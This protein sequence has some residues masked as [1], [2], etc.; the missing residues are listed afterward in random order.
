MT[1]KITL[2]YSYAALQAKRAELARVQY[3]EYTTR[4]NTQRCQEIWAQIE[5]IDAEIERRFGTGKEV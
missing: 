1:H 3:K 2:H 5:A 4:G